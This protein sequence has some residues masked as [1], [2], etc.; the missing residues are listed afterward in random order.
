MIPGSSSYELS[1]R[2]LIVFLFVLGFG[3]V[4]VVLNIA[5]RSLPAWAH[6]VFWID[7]VLLALALTAL[8][9]FS[10]AAR[11]RGSEE[12]R[13]GYTTAMSSS[14][15]LPQVDP[16]SGR[17]V[18]DAGAPFLTRNEFMSARAQYPSASGGPSHR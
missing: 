14:Q 9:A 4:G 8:G 2:G 17:V 11:R 13:A 12:V 10:L 18:R 7:F 5:A 6:V 16:R 3:V 1:R 15:E